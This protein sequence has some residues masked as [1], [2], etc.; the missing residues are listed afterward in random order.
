M[1]CDKGKCTAEFTVEKDMC[2]E[3]DTL[4]GAYSSLLL[5]NITTYALMSYYSP[6]KLTNSI[7][8]VTVSMYNQ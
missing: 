5:D 3:Y 1:T 2:N 8:G 7:K 4:H 6:E